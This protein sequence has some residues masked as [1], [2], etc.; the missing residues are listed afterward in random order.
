LFKLASVYANGVSCED[1][2]ALA[3][4]VPLSSL[5]QTWQASMAG[6]KPLPPDMQNITPYLV[7]LCLM[8]LIPLIGIASTMWKK[9]IPH[10]SK[11]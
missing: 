6:Q 4:G 8:L 9:G 10:G 2:P 5:E 3:F 7:L 1:G 11:K